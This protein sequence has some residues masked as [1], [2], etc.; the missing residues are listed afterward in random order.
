MIANSALW[1]KDD[2]NLKI[3]PRWL[4]TGGNMTAPFVDTHVAV[5]FLGGVSNFS[6]ATAPDCRFGCVFDVL[7][8]G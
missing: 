5:R 6:Q 7:S 4:G 3:L 2:P 8:N 1:H